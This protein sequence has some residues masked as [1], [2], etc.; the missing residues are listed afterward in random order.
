[1]EKSRNLYHSFAKNK[2]KKHLPGEVHD[3]WCFGLGTAHVK[4]LGELKKERAVKRYSYAPT[5][6]TKSICK[7]YH[8]LF[9]IEHCTSEGQVRLNGGENNKEGTVGICIGGVWGT[10]C[11]DYW[12][13]LDARVVCRQL[14]YTTD[15][16]KYTNNEYSFI[17]STLLGALAF[18][19]A[20]FGQGSG[21]IQ[22]DNVH[23]NGSESSLLDCNHLDQSNCQ[24]SADAGVRC[25]GD[26]IKL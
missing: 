13:T 3:C 15:G 20:Y 18:S 19:T 9:F 16:V 7:P 8:H 10:V 1:M 5:T 21:P 4:A 12:G 23:C 14:G 6:L 26:T 17:Y 22:I 25:Q 2:V 24:H 11:D